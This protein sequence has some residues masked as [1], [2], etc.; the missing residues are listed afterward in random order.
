VP[1]LRINFKDQSVEIWEIKPD[2][3]LKCPKNKAKWTAMNLHAERMG[4]KFTVVTE[5][6]IGTLR[7]KIR[8]QRAL[9]G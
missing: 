5:D 8:K 3:Q 1:D 6:G 9:N 7:S 4:W 2:A